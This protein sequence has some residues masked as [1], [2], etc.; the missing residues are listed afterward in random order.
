MGIWKLIG[1]GMVDCETVT[2][3]TSNDIFTAVTATAFLQT[4]RDVMK[5][6]DVDQDCSVLVFTAE[7]KGQLVLV[8]LLA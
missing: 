6:N 4:G 1:S 7:S 8:S 5:V 2:S 3:L